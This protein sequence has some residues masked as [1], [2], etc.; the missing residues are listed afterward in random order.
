MNGT[1]ANQ[2]ASAPRHCAFSRLIIAAGPRP[3]EQEP[4]ATQRKLDSEEIEPG[5]DSEEDEDEDEED[6]EGE[7]EEDED[8]EGEDEEDGIEEGEDEDEEGEVL[9]TE[10]EEAADGWDIWPAMEAFELHATLQ[11]VVPGQLQLSGICHLEFEVR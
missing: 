5:E 4:L 11:H 3:L 7:D 9:R 10:E 2:L 1:F 8:E 6:E